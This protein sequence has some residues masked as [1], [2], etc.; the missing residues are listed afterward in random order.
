[1]IKDREGQTDKTDKTKQENASYDMSFFSQN[2]KVK[3]SQISR[4]LSISGRLNKA[5]KT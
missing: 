5:P 3:Y 4:H 2:R 1:M